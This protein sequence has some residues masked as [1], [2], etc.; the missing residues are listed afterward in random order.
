MKNSGIGLCIYFIGMEVVE[1]FFFWDMDKISG[2][3]VFLF[4][5]FFC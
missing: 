2:I 1:D 5:L 3:V 4:S